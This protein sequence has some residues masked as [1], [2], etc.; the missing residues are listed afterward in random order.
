MMT[1]IY[2]VIGWMILSPFI[3]E[4]VLMYKTKKNEYRAPLRDLNSKLKPA[5]LTDMGEFTIIENGT[6]SGWFDFNYGGAFYYHFNNEVYITRE[7]H[8]ELDEIQLASVIGHELTHKKT[9]DRPYGYG[10]VRSLY[11]ELA[12]DRGS[13][14]RGTAKG[15]M[16]VILKALKKQKNTMDVQGQFLPASTVNILRQNWISSIMY[17][18]TPR[19]LVLWMF[20][21]I[22]R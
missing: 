18:H 9:K 5:L 16:D 8:D 11:M 10:L 12:A 6:W 15:M 14:S 13:L 21:L 7:L 4:L 22:G 3:G 1:F 2:I 20:H 19:I 17:I